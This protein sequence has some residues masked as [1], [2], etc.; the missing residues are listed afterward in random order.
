MS[1]IMLQVPFKVSQRSKYKKKLT[2]TN[3]IVKL[4]RVI[5]QVYPRRLLHHN[6]LFLLLLAVLLMISGCQPILAN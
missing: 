2:L 6:P 5:G 3:M 4:L 1:K